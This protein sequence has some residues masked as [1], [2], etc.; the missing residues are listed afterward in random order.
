MRSRTAGVAS[1]LAAVLLIAAPSAVPVCDA[2]S[3]V[4]ASADTFTVRFLHWRASAWGGSASG[5]ACLMEGPAGSWRAEILVHDSAAPEDAPESA[6]LDRFGQG[7]TLARFPDGP[8]MF[9][10]WGGPIRRFEDERAPFARV[11]RR[12]VSGGLAPG[13]DLPDGVTMVRDSRALSR[14]RR[15]PWLAD[16]PERSGWR[17]LF[18]ASPAAGPT[19]FRAVMEDR[20]RGRGSPRETWRVGVTPGAEHRSFRVTSSRR[21]GVLSLEPYALVQ[22]LGDR[23]EAA[24]PI[25]TLRE[26]LVFPRRDAEGF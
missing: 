17:I 25:W 16:Q 12:I 5:S 21:E 9:R 10:E 7:W 23:D 1:F 11:L 24:S 26:L 22:A 19:A 14:D 2:A 15:L 18:P 20:G 8:L 4:A 3:S 6:L 13:I